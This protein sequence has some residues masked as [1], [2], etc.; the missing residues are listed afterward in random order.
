[1]EKPMHSFPGVWLFFWDAQFYHKPV[2]VSLVYK[3]E[4]LQEFSIEDVINGLNS[5]ID[6][7]ASSSI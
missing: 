6:P 3:V 1:M 5:K 4:E 7:Y 2:R